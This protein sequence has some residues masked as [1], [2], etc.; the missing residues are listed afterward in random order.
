S[1][2]L[3]LVLVEPVLVPVEVVVVCVDVVPVVVLLPLVVVVVVLVPVALWVPV[4]SPALAGVAGQ[5]LGHAVFGTQT[6]VVTPTLQQLLMTHWS[7]PVQSALVAQVD[8]P[9]QAK[10]H[11]HRVPVVLPSICVW[12]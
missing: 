5:V 9:E 8:L 12:K 2:E 1:L 6:P 4:A 7:V 3:V 11:R 10:S